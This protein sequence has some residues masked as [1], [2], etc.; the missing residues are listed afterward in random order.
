MWTLQ[1]TRKR[2][3]AVVKAALHRTPREMTRRGKP[4]VVLLACEEYQ[5]LLAAAGGK[6]ESFAEHLLAFASDGALD[7]GR[8][9]PNRGCRVCFP[10]SIEAVR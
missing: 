8:L 5:C 4:A 2:F 6:P 1:G 9:R 7:T 10:I 3:S